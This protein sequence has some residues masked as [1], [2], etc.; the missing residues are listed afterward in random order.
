M[1]NE[2]KDVRKVVNLINQI[3]ELSDKQ[4]LGNSCMNYDEYKKELLKIINRD[5]YCVEYELNEGEFVY[6]SILEALYEKYSYCVKR[7]FQDIVLK[8]TNELRD[9][10]YSSNELEHY[11]ISKYRVIERITYDPNTDL[12]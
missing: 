9:V 11:S 7:E 2:D 12:I 5:N 10:V 4:L 6:L 8:L 3:N 1:K